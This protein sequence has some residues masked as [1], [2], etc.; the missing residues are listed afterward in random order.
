M[1]APNADL[2]RQIQQHQRHL[3]GLQAAVYAQTDPAADPDFH[4]QLAQ[5]ERELHAL[6]QQLAAAL[7]AEPP[8]PA[9]AARRGRLLGPETTGLRVEPTLHMQPLPTGIYHLLGPEDA[10]LLTVV[11]G[12]E[13]QDRKPRRVCVKAYLEGLSAEAVRTVEVKRGEQVTLKLLPTL[14]PERARLMTEVQRAT[15]HLRVEDLDGKPECHDTFPL[16]CL[17]RT[18]G[19]NAVEDP[20]TGRPVDLTHYYGAWVTPYAEAVQERVRRAAGLCPAGLLCGY[21]RGPAAVGPQVTALYQALREAGLVY[22]N[23]V[24]DY[25]AAAGQT[26]QRTR[27]PREALGLKSANCIDGAVLFASLLEGASLNAAL[28]LVPGHALAGWEADDGAGDW[29]FLETTMVGTHDFEAACRSGQR[30]YE[31]AREYYPES[32]RL[33]PLADLR[34]RGIWPME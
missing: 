24:I 11:I 18:S 4:R 5:E 20:Q 28:L 3:R 1:A 13:S 21:Q 17:A 12:N 19:F 10:P 7:A 22:V 6:K 8:G 34:A 33:H 14:F 29:R 32:M 31:Q 2:H 26:T 25:G 23:S 15:L 16:V 9:T 27:L 30:Q